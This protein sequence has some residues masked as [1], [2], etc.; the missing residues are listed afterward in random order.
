MVVSVGIGEA[1]LITGIT[2][3]VVRGY[4]TGGLIGRVKGYLKGRK[5]GI[6]SIRNK[7]TD[8]TI[9]GIQNSSP[10]SRSHALAANPQ[11]IKAMGS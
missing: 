4:G 2:A 7:V 5:A 6:D 10:T 1:A 3:G 8:A 9:Q 11:A